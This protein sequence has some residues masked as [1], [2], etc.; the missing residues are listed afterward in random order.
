MKCPFLLQFPVQVFLSVSALGPFLVLTAFI[1]PP[2]EGPSKK[3]ETNE[4]QIIGRG[5]TAQFILVFFHTELVILKI[6]ESLIRS[7]KI[8]V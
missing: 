8:E 5:D 7:V 4:P 6:R 2:L 3:R 1:K